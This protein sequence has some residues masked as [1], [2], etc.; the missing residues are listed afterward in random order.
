M[1]CINGGFDAIFP[2]TSKSEA[3]GVHLP[4]AV[5][6]CRLADSEEAQ[7]TVLPIQVNQRPAQQVLQQAPK[8]PGKDPKQREDFYA[9]IGEAI[10]TLKEEIPQL[11]QK[12]LTCVAPLMNPEGQALNPESV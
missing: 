4:D 2:L 11:F 7:S 9:N 3:L 10:R 6:D 1:R 5:Q 8:P 12:D